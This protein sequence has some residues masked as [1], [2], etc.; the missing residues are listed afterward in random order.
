MPTSTMVNRKTMAP[1]A[2]R[3]RKP[4]FT[5]DAT[6][7]QKVEGET[8][9]RRNLASKD[10]LISVPEPGVNTIYDILKRGS[11]KFGNAKCVGYR[12]L[13][14]EHQEKK[15]ITKMVDGKETK[16]DKT[17]NYFE[18]SE[19]QYMSFIEY[20]RQAKSCGAGLRKLGM[21]SGDKLHIFATTR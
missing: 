17:W 15:Q 4:P 2:Q 7:V 14:R 1:Q 10:G 6:G 13:I 5:V 3:V 12:K 9:P 8:I 21:E 16:T 19:Y 20:E 18:L 11:E